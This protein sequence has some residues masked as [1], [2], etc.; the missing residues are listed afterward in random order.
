MSELQGWFGDDDKCLRYLER[1]RWPTGVVCP[2]CGAK[3]EPWRQSRG[4]LTCRACRQQT[5]VLTGT[6]FEKTRVPLPTWFAAT[7]Y[8]TSQKFGASALGL[9]RVLGLGSYQTAWTMLH[10]MRCA[11]VRPDRYRL[12]GDVEVDE[13]YIG[14]EGEGIGGRYARK[15]AI[16]AIALEIK[17]PRGYGRVRL[18]RI[19]DVSAASLVP[20]VSEVADPSAVIFSDAWMGYRPLTRHGF[21]HKRTSIN[22]SDEPATVIMPG[23]HRVASLLKRWL[24]GTH[25]GA[26]RSDH[27][28]A[29]LDEY[30]FR[31][32]R[33]ASRSRGLLFYRLLQQSVMSPRVT[34]R[35]IVDGNPKI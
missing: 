19:P 5:T 15:K 33:R 35:Q 32:N 21:T 29:Y 7:W 9:Q 26:V 30:T 2:A 11:M 25:Q 31:F 3:G 24:L 1:L 16:V 22:A 20:F 23:V 4:R 34:Y 8:V 28:D 13:T 10:K 14:S 12:Q 27:L 17:R 18:R 6:I